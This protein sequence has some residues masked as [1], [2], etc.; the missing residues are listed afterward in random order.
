VLAVG[1]TAS[2]LFAISA[3]E[4]RSLAEERA[5]ALQPALDKAR[6]EQQRADEKAQ[7]ARTKADELAAA[8]KTAEEARKRAQ[9]ALGEARG[10][11]QAWRYAIRLWEM[12]I[13]R[14]D[15]NLRKAVLA[16]LHATLAVQL[17]LGGSSREEVAEQSA[18]AQSLAPDDA[19]V[20][21]ACSHAAALCG[22]W[23]EAATAFGRGLE[24]SGR[25]RVDMEILAMLQAA[26]GDQEG[27]RESCRRLVGWKLYEPELLALIVGENAVDDWTPAIA[28]ARRIAKNRNLNPMSQSLL[29]A[30]YFQAR[31]TDDAAQALS[32]ASPLYAMARLAAPD[33]KDAIDLASLVTEVYLAR[34]YRDLGK[35]D[36]SKK[37]RDRAWKTIVRMEESPPNYDAALPVWSLKFGVDFGKRNL[38]RYFDGYAG[39]TER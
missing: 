19:G 5:D 24:L 15:D 14:I 34:A 27:Y 8:L 29:G 26:A 16:N 30:I 3:T 11:Q 18:K 20:L 2:S 6:R 28:A 23:G 12:T 37:A 7:E 35:E 33:R 9:V 39:P 17:A 21:V 4:A 1:T 32:R 22:D 25:E 13:P 10:G 31:Q 36:E 38:A